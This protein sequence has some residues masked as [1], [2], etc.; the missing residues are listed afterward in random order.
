LLIDRRISLHF[1]FAAAN[2]A[3]NTAMM[4]KIRPVLN[5]VGAGPMKE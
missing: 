5:P 4:Q 2:P 1:F 3:R